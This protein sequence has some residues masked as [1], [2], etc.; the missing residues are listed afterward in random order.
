[1]HKNKRIGAVR[2]LILLAVWGMLVLYP[3]AQEVKS[4]KHLDSLYNAYLN[5]RSGLSMP[6][7]Q[8]VEG[9]EASKSG[10]KCGFGL[11][12]SVWRN[13]N[14]FSAEQ[15]RVLKKLIEDRPVLDTSIVSPSGHFRIHFNTK[16]DSIPRYD[17]RLSLREN[18]LQVAMALDSS[19][20]YEVNLLHF[21]PPPSD[22]GVGGDNL[23]DVYIADINSYGYTQPGTSLDQA[24]LTSTSYIVID[25]NFSDADQVSTFGL[26]GMYVT[27]AHE[28]NHAIQLGSYNALLNNNELFFYEATSTAMEELVFDTVNDYY[29][30]LRDYFNNPDRPFYDYNS[31]QIYSIGIWMLFQHYRF[32]PDII[33]REWEFFHQ[34]PALKA[35]NMGLTEQNSSFKRALNEFGLWTYF[36][37]FR[38]K[39]GEYFKE[40]ANY[41]LI[42]ITSSVSFIPPQQTV[43]IT[44]QPLT[45]NFYRFITDNGKTADTVVAII[46]DGDLSSALN[47]PGSYQSLSYSFYNY[48]AD[49][50]RKIANNYYARMSSGALD[51]F[52]ESDIFN[53][54]VAGGQNFLVGE[55]DYAFPVPFNYKQNT[56]LFIPVIPNK[57][58]TV[59][60]KI[61]TSS[62]DLV[63]S[64]NKNIVSVSEK[65][66]VEW[67]AMDSKNRKLPTGVYIFVTESEG[68]IK[69]G[70]IV[71]QNE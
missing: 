38:K 18:V 2:I 12:A 33:R 19:Y 8:Q 65:Y 57:M 59:S 24:G 49:G 42:R 58:N 6:A 60:I 1:M 46:T 21:L 3:N 29:Y 13:Y 43:E 41:P 61:F 71:I 69:K 44:T 52:A 27:A 63:F 15:R 25:D 26:N 4:V 35:M 20:N 55:I 32:G 37:G 50:A 11:A 54:N 5:L 40:G 48:A 10:N 17:S 56:Q 36:T 16:G 66:V 62:M 31:N 23:Y 45:N 22:N 68:N 30:Y 7:T 70:K 9:V 39:T 64:G 47:N 67:N 51:I 14:S 28:L 34:N 53:N